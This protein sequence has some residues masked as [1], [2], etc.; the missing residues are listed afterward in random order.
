[1]SVCFFSKILLNEIQLVSTEHVYGYGMYI[2]TGLRFLNFVDALYEE[3]KKTI[4]YVWNKVALKL[5]KT[6]TCS[7]EKYVHIS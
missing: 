5:K 7:C 6:S 3:G 4:Y 1:L 2:V